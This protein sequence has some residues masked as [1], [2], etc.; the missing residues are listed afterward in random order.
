[1]IGYPLGAGPFAAELLGLPGY[2]I[3]ERE[4]TVVGPT[5]WTQGPAD[6]PI[7]YGVVS[8]LTP[9]LPHFPYGYDVEPPG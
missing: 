5:L 9:P 7:E 6:M 4:S 3:C 8:I 1:M 2:F